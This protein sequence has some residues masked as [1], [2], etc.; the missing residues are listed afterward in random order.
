MA[1]NIDIQYVISYLQNKNTQNTSSM[2]VFRV[3]K[4]I[5]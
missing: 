4:F 3:N 2:A 1:Y 5:P